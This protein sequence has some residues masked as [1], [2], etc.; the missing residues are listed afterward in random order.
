[1]NER[2]FPRI[3]TVS[4]DSS[5]RWIARAEIWRQKD[6]SRSAGSHRP[7]IFL[8]H[9]HFLP[10]LLTRAAPEVKEG[11][12]E[13]LALPSVVTQYQ[14]VSSMRAECP[15]PRRKNLLKYISIVI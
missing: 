15:F 3:E 4:T 5:V 8:L 2:E 12:P 6:G 13:A 9:A 10:H 11:A 1:M 7:K 14:G